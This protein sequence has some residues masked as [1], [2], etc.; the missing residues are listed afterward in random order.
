MDSSLLLS[1]AAVLAVLGGY[2]IVRDVVRLQRADRIRRER[3]RKLAKEGVP[4]EDPNAFVKPLDAG[5]QTAVREDW[6][7]TGV[8]LAAVG[9]GAVFLGRQIGYGQFAVGVYTA[10]LCGIVVGVALALLGGVLHVLSRPL[11]QGK[12]DV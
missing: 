1:L 11:A 4:I 9:V 12:D 5:V 10:G 7:L 6:T 3:L 2:R 8:L